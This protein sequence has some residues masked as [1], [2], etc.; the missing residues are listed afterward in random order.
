MAIEAKKA[1]I[2]SLMA[3][4]ETETDDARRLSILQQIVEL[5][6]GIE[7]IYRGSDGN[8]GLFSLMRH[9]VLLAVARADVNL[10]YQTFLSGQ[11]QIEERFAQAMGD[12]LIDGYWANTSYAPGQEELLYR[13]ACEI[14]A[15]LS[16]PSV[17]Y[18]V[19]VQNLSGI[20]GY[21]QESFTIN[22]ALRIWDEALSLND[23]AYVV[24]LEENPET[25]EKDSLTI[26]NDLTSIGGVTLDGIISSITGIAEILNQKKALY[27]RSRAISADGSIP[28]KRLEGMIDVL[29]TRLSSSISNWYTDEDGNLILEA[30]NGRSAMQLCGEGFMIASSKTDDGKWDWRTF[31]SGEGFTAD[32]LVTGFLS[33]DRIQTHT[34]TAVKLAADVGESLD[35]SSNTSINLTVRQTVASEIQEQIGYRVEISTDMGD[36]LSKY[37]PSTILRAH[38]WRGAT[39]VTDQ[40]EANRFQWKRTSADVIADQLWNAA[41]QGVKHIHLTTS[42]VFY[43]A[44]Y[45]CEILGAE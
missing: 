44:T 21:E 12:M 16:K 41:H 15:H 14:M 42:D 11:R 10:F 38:V 5:E 9:A 33:A 36:V 24:K 3:K 45:L 1:S 7:A 26:S 18:T 20:S 6:T 22:M 43:S 31:G 4:L 25:P 29:K 28:A 37:V 34:I 27:D 39:E 40:I 32:M 17:S 8:E 19:S 2:E 35:L 23:I 30:V 13:E